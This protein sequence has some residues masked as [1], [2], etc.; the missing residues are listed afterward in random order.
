MPVVATSGKLQNP[1]Y[2]GG[3]D[4]RRSTPYSVSEVRFV[5]A[6]CADERWSGFDGIVSCARVTARR[7]CEAQ[8]TLGRLARTDDHVDS[9]GEN[10]AA[11][12][13]RCCCSPDGGIS[14]PGRVPRLSD[15][16]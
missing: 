1:P 10:V 12:C 7:G 6:L 16:H 11:S 4:G 13:D 8:P 2:T 3:S 14:P 5:A 15:G 9:G